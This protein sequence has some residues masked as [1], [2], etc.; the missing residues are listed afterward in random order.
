MA[1]QASQLPQL[2]S[3]NDLLRRHCRDRLYVPPLHWTAQHIQLLRC[4]FVPHPH[5]PQPTSSTQ[6][7]LTPSNENEQS[8]EVSKHPPKQADI[9]L[10]RSIWRLA[11]DNDL[12]HKQWGLEHLLKALSND[13]VVTS[14]PDYLNLYYAGRPVAR[15]PCHVFSHVI[16]DIPIPF[17]AYVDHIEV[18][19]FR[20]NSIPTPRCNLPVWNIRKAKLARLQPT[21]IDQD[22]YFVGILIALAQAWRHSCSDDTARQSPHTVH[23]LV[24]NCKDIG[25]LKLYTAIVTPA[26]LRK[27]DQPSV[28][29]DS[30]LII[31][32]AHI[33]SKPV[34]YIKH[35]I[36]AVVELSRG[37]KRLREWSGTTEQ[38][39]C[40][41]KKQ[42]N[43]NGGR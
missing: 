15:L 7:R 28:F 5:T 43:R 42:G 9:R 3:L 31:Q 18:A 39:A 30:S 12:L 29:L 35:E 32:C 1:P 26:F 10:Q 23:L 2:L 16:D 34:S 13:R 4:R 19:R 27:F 41:R 17:L 33:P 25:F 20:E 21:N 6:A 14:L 37:K 38:G 40:K 24:T 11:R 22:P 36:A 8:G